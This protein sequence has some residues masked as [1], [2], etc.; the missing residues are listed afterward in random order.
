MKVV[1]ANPPAYFENNHDHFINAGSR[2]SHTFKIPKGVGIPHG[3]PYPFFLGYSS[4]LLKRDSS[5]EV[6]V[7]DGCASCMDVDE[8]TKRILFLGPEILVVEIPSICWDLMM[9]VLQ[10]LKGELDCRIIVSGFHASALYNEII[11]SYSFI[12]YILVG[13][14]EYSLLN[15]INNL[16]HNKNPV[17]RVVFSDCISNLDDLPFPDRDGLPLLKYYNQPVSGT[18]CIYMWSSRG[19]PMNCGFCVE[20]QVLYGNSVYR[21]RNPHTVVEEMNYCV[22]V[23]NARQI[24]FDDMTFSGN[25]NHVRSI[26]REIIRSGLDIPWWA[27]VD[28]NLDFDTLKMMRDSGCVK[29]AFGVESIDYGNLRR[30]SKLF[31]QK[32]KV[33][34]FK[35]WCDELGLLSHATFTIGLPGDTREKAFSCLDFALSL[36]T[37]T[38]QWSIAT[39]Y[40]GTRFYEDVKKNGFLRDVDWKYFDGTC[41]S[42]VS[43]PDFSYDSIEKCHHDICSRW[44]VYKEGL[45]PYTFKR[46]TVKALGV[47]SDARGVIS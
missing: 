16:N 43:Y 38:A 1:L 4:A 42:V 26:C 28:V 25:H 41:S 6:S 3:H 27:M 17:K 34:Q 19:C 30:S 33:I 29:V 36:D 44:W 5:V 11:E 21:P 12:D 14:Y 23:Y 13:E 7:V 15:L 32:D 46:A 40:P 37:S 10:F 9:P 45:I 18:P 24:N 8:F 22:D 35:R 2:W 20:R 47:L 39:P 31:V